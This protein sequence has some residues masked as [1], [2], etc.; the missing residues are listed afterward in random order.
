MLLLLRKEQ[1]SIMIG[2]DIQIQIV[3]FDGKN[4]LLGIKAPRS[5]PV[6]RQEIYDKINFMM[7]KLKTVFNPKLENKDKQ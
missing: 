6:H 4:V 3:G 5:I 7:N 2:D 1:E